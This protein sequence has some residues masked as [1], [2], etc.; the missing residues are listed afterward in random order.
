M[1]SRTLHF[2]LAVFVL[3]GWQAWGGTARADTTADLFLTEVNSL[4]LVHGLA[5]LVADP[6]LTSVAQ[7]WSQEMA[8]TQHLE[9]NPNLHA[10][11]GSG[12]VNL[13]ENV[14][15]G[16]TLAIIYNGLLGSPPHLANMLSSYTVT[17][18]GVASSGTY[19]WVTEVFAERAGS[20]PPT[21]AAPAP[22]TAPPTTVRTV[23]V[24]APTVPRTTTS[25]SSSTTSTSTSASTSTTPTTST[26]APLPGT[27]R[28]SGSAGAASALVAGDPP[29]TPPLALGANPAL[30]RSHPS[31]AADFGWIVAISLLGLGAVAVIAVAVARA[32]RSS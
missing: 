21:T 2:L 12:F 6:T 10:D 1:G 23:Y 27:A 16:G 25:A 24:P 20:S 14:A 4:R 9:E 28:V 18:I 5:A 29:T 17:G 26:P 3:A 31:G 8:S 30:L 13:G 19:L 11:V 22:T 15:Y 7:N 32:V